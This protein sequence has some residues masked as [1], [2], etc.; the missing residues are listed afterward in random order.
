MNY[1]LVCGR[2]L[3][4]SLGPIGPV[5]MKKLQGEN[6]KHRIRGMSREKYADLAED[7]DIFSGEGDEIRETAKAACEGERQAKS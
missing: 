1:C 6:R 5:C 2:K 3:T 4:K 7:L